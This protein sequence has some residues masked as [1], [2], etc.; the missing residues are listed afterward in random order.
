VGL[1]VVRGVATG[2]ADAGGGV[3]DADGDGVDGSDGSGATDADGEGV[4][5]SDNAV[6]VMDGTCP[7]V[8]ASRTLPTATANPTPTTT[9]EMATAAANAARWGELLMLDHAAL[10]RRSSPLDR[11]G[12]GAP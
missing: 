7:V 2:E 5:V 4:D 10:R 12:M 9:A 1:G 11:L 8:G 3:G 6:G